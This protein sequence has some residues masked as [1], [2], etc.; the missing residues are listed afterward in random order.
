MTPTAQAPKHARIYP[1]LLDSNV[2]FFKNGNDLKVIS[3]GSIFDF[4]DLPP[5]IY[6]II[7]E[8]LNSEKPAKK[9]LEKWFP[10]SET[11]QLKKFT[12]CRFGALDFTPD[13]SNAILQDG[14]Y[15]DCPKRGSCEGEGI[16]CKNIK[17]QGV[18]L[19]TQDIDLMKLL[20]TN[21]TNNV[22]AEKHQVSFG[23]LHKLKKNL[24]AKTNSQT[25]Q[26]I[27]NVIAKLNIL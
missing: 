6:N 26:C 15:W 27:G 13:I 17:Y 7:S 8:L 4:K 24:Y 22:I 3:N 5:I 14:E 11:K 20:V 16:V 21:D 19:T 18:E 10:K 25:R 9:I 1:G 12:E 2:E 23:Q